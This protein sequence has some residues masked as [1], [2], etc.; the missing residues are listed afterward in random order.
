MK[1]LFLDI[2]GVLLHVGTQGLG[3]TSGEP[4]GSSFYFA[5]TLDPACVLRLKKVL[6]ATGARVVVSSV[7]RTHDDQMTGL[8]RAMLNAGYDRQALRDVFVGAT[9][10]IGQERD[11]EVTAWLSK[12]PEVT[13][14]V[15]LDDGVVG[16]HPQLDSRPNH[17]EGGLLDSH[18]EALVALLG[19]AP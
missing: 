1:V 12:H 2:D 7:W 17:F 8:R 13:K 14:Y 4:W 5:A 11:V 10:V 15:V 6:D 19:G 9:P 3:R 16:S 18:V